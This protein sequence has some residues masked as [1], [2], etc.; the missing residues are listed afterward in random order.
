MFREVFRVAGHLYKMGPPHP[1]LL[2]LIKYAEMFYGFS[3]VDA[4]HDFVNDPTSYLTRIQEKSRAGPDLIELLNLHQQ[5][6]EHSM[7]NRHL[8]LDGEIGDVMAALG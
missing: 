8:R 7:A 4:A 1:S 3:S 6:L 5:F 2:G